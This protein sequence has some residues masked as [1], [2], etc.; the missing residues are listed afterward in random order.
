MSTVSPSGEPH[1]ARVDVGLVDGKLW[2]SATLGRVR[3][4]H[5]RNDPRAALAVLHA[6]NSYQWLGL[7]CRV[8]ILEGPDAPDLNLELYRAIAKE[9]DDVAEYLE[10]MVAEERIIYEFEILR[11]YGEF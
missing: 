2:S 6:S 1:V 11:F 9:P 8:T 3:T 7:S 10:A 4:R 5:L